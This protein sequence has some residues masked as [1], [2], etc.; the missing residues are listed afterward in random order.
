MNYSQAKKA[1][2]EGR[3]VY[4][5]TLGRYP[6]GVVFS[7]SKPGIMNRLF[8][9]PYVRAHTDRHDRAAVK[10][11]LNELGE[12]SLSAYGAFM[13]SLEKKGVDEAVII[14]Y[15]TGVDDDPH[16]MEVLDRHYA[17][18]EGRKSITQKRIDEI[19]YK[20]T[21]DARER[22]WLQNSLQDLDTYGTSWERI[23]G[24]I[25]ERTH[26]AESSKKLLDGE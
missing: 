21:V 11:A 26:P 7:I 14:A 16:V 1:I 18:S 25:Y 24:E 12:A 23:A 8:S 10:D 4:S 22:A 15:A 19:K 20:R 13:K 2:V 5:Q 17:R 3:R 6:A 9:T